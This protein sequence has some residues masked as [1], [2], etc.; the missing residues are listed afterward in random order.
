MTPG[1]V[2]YAIDHY[3]DPRRESLEAFVERCFRQTDASD[4]GA[5]LGICADRMVT[6]Q[7]ELEEQD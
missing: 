2:A 3:W 1:Q 7:F 6:A 5:G 4:I